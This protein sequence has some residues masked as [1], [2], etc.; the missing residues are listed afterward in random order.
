[1]QQKI[2]EMHDMRFKLFGKVF[3]Y[4]ECQYGLEQ[5]TLMSLMSYFF[6]KAGVKITSSVKNSN[7]PNNIAK[8][9]IDICKSVRDA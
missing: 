9:Q 6:Q 5:S 8:L 7:L 3:F 1:M 4:S 2:V